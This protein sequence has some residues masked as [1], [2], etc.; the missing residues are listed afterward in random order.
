MMAPII[1]GMIAC[2]LAAA[3]VAAIR[4]AAPQS[5]RTVGWLLSVSGALLG[6]WAA[7]SLGGAPPELKIGMPWPFPPAALQLRD[8][9]AGCALLAGLL[10]IATGWLR[11]ARTAAGGPGTGVLLHVLLLGVAWFLASPR[12]L[13]ML[14]GWEALSATSYVLLIRDRLRVRRAAWALLG[15]S[16]FGTGLL[17]FALLVAAAHGW[18]LAPAWAVALALCGLFA[19]GAKAGLFPLQVWVPLAEPEAPG[20]VA[21]LFSGLLTAVAVVGYLRIVH[22]LSPPLSTVGVVTAAFGL[23]GA[24]ASALLGLV[25]RDTKRVLAY[26]TLEALGLVFTSLGVGMVLQ[27]HGAGSAAEMAVAGALILLAAHAGAKFTLFSLA[28]WLEERAGMRLLDRMGGV[29]GSM[30]RGGGPLVVAVATL[31]ALPPFGGFLGEWLL[32]EAC[33]VP[34]PSQPGL[35]IALAVLAAMAAIVAAV[36]LTVYLRWIGIGFLGRA[37][38]PG[39]RPLTDLPRLG[40]AGQ[41]LAA[42]VGMGS[43][44]GAGWLLPWL[45]RATRWLAS[46]APVIAPTYAHPAAYA[47]IVALGAGLF[48]GIAGSSGN[49]IFAAGGFNVGSPWDLACCGILLALAVALVTG[50]LRA[51]RPRLARTWVGG[52]PDDSV[53]LSWTAEA[54]NQP[55]RL[56]FATFFALERSRHPSG[57]ALQGSFRYRSRMKLRL[58]HHVYRPLLGLATRTSGAVRQTVQSGDLGHYVGYLLGAAVLGILAVKL[59]R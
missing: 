9:G 59:W 31:A 51:R 58:E 12:P 55:L 10:F 33:L 37:R 42:A 57:D 23:L 43:G 16:E 49:V 48:R 45:G 40:A 22:L 24:A 14:V 53:R 38:T 44:I 46:G 25:E 3:L 47:P 27:G 1:G 7:T 41:W 19:F 20:D 26:G 15:L 17:F 28:G 30:P 32:I 21:G 18:V 4:P 54:L 11:A 35:H 36:G 13:P 2:A 29:L 52:E 6:V 34:I 56:T 8:L 39:A 5:S 50:R